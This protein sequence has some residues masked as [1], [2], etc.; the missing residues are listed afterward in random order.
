[1]NADEAKIEVYSSEVESY[2]GSIQSISFVPK[3]SITLGSELI[4][5]VYVPVSDLLKSYTVNDLTY[6][7]AEIVTLDDGKSYYHIKVAMPASE[8]AENITLKT[9]LTVNGSEY[10][11]SFTMSIPAYTK[12]VIE[13]QTSPEEVT[14]VKDVLAY[15]R[16]A[17][18]YFDAEGKD[19]AI[20]TIDEI[21]GDYESEFGKVEGNTNTEEGL[22]TVIIVLGDKPIVRFVIP[23]GASLDSYTFKAGNSVLDY[24][25]GTYTEG[26]VEY[27]YAEVELYA[28]Q[29][30][31]EIT[32]TAGEYSGSY[33]INSYYDFVTTDETYKTDTNL[34]S[35]VEKLYTYCKSAE[36]YRTSVINS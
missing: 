35:L 24:T 29:L 4:Y 16:A 5:N 17:Y 34:I 30:I 7:D 21:L 12:K 19:E 10:A 27:T 18:V 22:K 15:I 13:A 1:L 28:Y 2:L 11:G 32:Y 26:G 23:E 36:A 31:G 33:H 3:V 8:A 6:E 14:L 9:V 20:A 25:T